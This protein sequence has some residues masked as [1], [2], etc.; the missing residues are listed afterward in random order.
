MRRIHCVHEECCDFLV[1]RITCN[2][3]S[4]LRAHDNGDMR[5]CMETRKTVSL[6]S[7]QPQKAWLIEKMGEHQMSLIFR[8]GVELVEHVVHATGLLVERRPVP[9]HAVPLD[10]VPDAAGEVVRHADHH[11]QRLAVAGHH[12]LVEEP[13]HDLVDGVVGSPDRLDG[14]EAVEELGGEG[15]EVPRAGGA[16]AVVQS[17][18]HRRHLAGERGVVRARPHLGRRAQVVPDEVAPKLD[19]GALPAAVGLPRRRQPRLSPEAPD[20]LVHVQQQ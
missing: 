13:L 8:D 6:H 17:V 16:L 15:G 19:V 11:L 2:F 3:V 20:Q 4:H 18:H 10:H 5:I 1:N 14:L 9:L 7:K 12:V